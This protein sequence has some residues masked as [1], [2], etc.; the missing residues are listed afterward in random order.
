MKNGKNSV[1]PPIIENNEVINDA[2]T[3]VAY[4][5]TFLHLKQLYLATMFLYPICVWF[6]FQITPFGQSNDI[7]SDLSTI[8]TSPIP[9]YCFASSDW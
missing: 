1:I 4:L 3:K 7:F 8:N 2:Q 6:G 5:M 9:Y